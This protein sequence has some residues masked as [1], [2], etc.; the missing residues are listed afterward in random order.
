MIFA[1]LTEG[2]GPQVSYKINDNDYS[3][4]YYLVDEIYP[5]WA[6]FVKIIPEPYGNKKKYFTK[7]QE[8]CRK[9]VGR[10]F[11]VLQSHFVYGSGRL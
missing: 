6:T 3:M 4:G 2:Q 1:R 5:S 7:A 9:D 10:A 11:G 8:A